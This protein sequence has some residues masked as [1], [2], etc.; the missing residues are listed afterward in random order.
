MNEVVMRKVRKRA[1]KSDSDA[2]NKSWVPGQK[3]QGGEGFS[4][5]Y[6]GS[7]G[8]GT[9]ASGPDTRK[10]PKSPRDETRRAAACGIS[11]SVSL[12]SPEILAEVLR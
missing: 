10:S 8:D 9:G 1:A 11:Y 6:G 12:P 2:R 5:G 7:A 4:D 3:G